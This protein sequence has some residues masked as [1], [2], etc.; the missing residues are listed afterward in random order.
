[1]KFLDLQLS[2]CKHL[3]LEKNAFAFFRAD[4]GKFKIFTK[5]EI[6]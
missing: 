5:I 3:H 4:T 6:P 1:M 2:R